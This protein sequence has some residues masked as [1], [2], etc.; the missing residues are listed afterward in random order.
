ADGQHPQAAAGRVAYGG[1]EV[2]GGLAAGGRQL[3]RRGVGQCAVE[4]DAEIVAVRLVGGSGYRAQRVCRLQSVFIQ[5]GIRSQVERVA[6]AERLQHQQHVVAEVGS[7]LG[8]RLQKGGELGQL[9]FGAGRIEVG[10][11]E[12]IQPGGGLGGGAGQRL[13]GGVH[14]GL[15]R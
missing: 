12:V 4:R 11:D 13:V 15:A 5:Q 7:P 3:H 9:G 10:L 6:V 14:Q 8:R 1:A 2:D